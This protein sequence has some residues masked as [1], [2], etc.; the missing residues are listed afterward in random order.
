MGRTY[1]LVNLISSVGFSAFWRRQC[2]RNLSIHQ[3]ACVCDMMSGTGECWPYL[4]RSGARSIASVDFSRTMIARQKLR[5][6]FKKHDVASL[7]ENAIATSIPDNSMDF[8]VSAFGLKTLNQPLIRKFAREIHRMLKPGGRFSL[9][10]ISFPTRWVFKPL[11]RWYVNAAIPI[12][13]R[14]CLG[15]MECYRMLGAYVAAFGSCAKVAPVFRDI[16]LKVSVKAHFYGCATSLV[17]CK[18]GQ[19]ERECK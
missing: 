12:I 14:A 19:D 7:C 17:G 18:A 5:R 8:V 13:G 2:V 11:Y 15:D 4:F 16:G 10:E 6:A 9:I 1:H 3:G